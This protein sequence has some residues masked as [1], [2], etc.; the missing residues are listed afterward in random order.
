M[1]DTLVTSVAD[2]RGEEPPALMI[3]LLPTADDILPLLRQIDSRRVYSND[4][5][6]AQSFR[7]ELAA[8]LQ[9][10]TSSPTPLHVATVVNG[11]T[12]IELALRLRAGLGRYVIMPAYTFVATAH[13][14]VN[15]GFE[16]WFADVNPQSWALTPGIVEALLPSLVEAPAAVVAVSPYGAPLDQHAWNAFEERTG[17][18]VVLDMAAGALSLDFVGRVPACL[19]LHATKMLGIGEGG[20][21][22]S[23]DA[24]LIAAARTAS[25]F[26]FDPGT[27]MASRRGGNYRISEYAAAIG[28]AALTQMSKRE[29]RLKSI[30]QTYRSCFEGVPIGWQPGFGDNWVAMTLNIRLPAEQIEATTVALNTR[31]IPWRRWWSLGCHTHPAFA[32]SPCGNLTETESLAPATIGLPFHEI[33]TEGQIRLVVDV[34]RKSLA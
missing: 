34:V 32:Q 6:L 17:I 14:V 2:H 15:A 25:S 3:P 4:G 23:Q 18:P 31:G 16:P 26:G 27:R 11:T 33:I 24:E 8:M 9:S 19:S 30:A 13:A 7:A 1:A 10:R 29:T 22:V 12:A 20:A 21:I 5:P 28:H